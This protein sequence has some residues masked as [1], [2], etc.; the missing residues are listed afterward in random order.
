MSV[1]LETRNG[2]A[3]LTMDNPPENAF[4]SDM[5]SLFNRFLDDIESDDALG[6][7]VIT[8]AGDQFFS[9]GMDIQYVMKLETDAL[10]RFFKELFT[11]F[12]RVFLF[13]KPMVAAVN[14]H[15][16]AS[17]LAFSMCL[18]YRVMKKEKAVCTFPEIDVSIMPPSGCL[19]MVK[20][21]VGNRITDL[22]FLSGRKFN[23]PAAL[24]A[25]MVDELADPA[26]VVDRAVEVA[27]ELG[28]KKP[29]L[30][31][32]YKQRFRGETA[33]C[34]LAED[35][36]Y[37]EEEMDVAMFQNCDLSCLQSLG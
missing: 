12:H 6:G 9:A 13:P 22:A 29:R 7:V 31:A 11:F 15:V 8:G 14:G 19:A 10:K 27:V 25:G 17:A 30:F 18:D 35:M 16:V 32:A 23:G 3:I 26:G 24:N 33:D 34:M 2:I 1:R 36:R 37:I 5:I 21:V 20:Y 4:N 28:A